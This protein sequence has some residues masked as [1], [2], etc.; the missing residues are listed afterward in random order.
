MFAK[1][2][3][4]FIRTRKTSA[5]IAKSGATIVGRLRANRPYL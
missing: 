4:T 3:R 2:G 1:I 5:P